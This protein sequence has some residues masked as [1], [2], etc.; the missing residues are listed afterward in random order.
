MASAL[1]TPPSAGPLHERITTPSLSPPPEKACGRSGRVWKEGFSFFSIRFLHGYITLFS[2]FPNFNR[3]IEE[4]GGW[5]FFFPR[6]LLFV[7]TDDFQIAARLGT[8]LFPFSCPGGLEIGITSF[9]PFPSLSEVIA[10]SS[11]PSHR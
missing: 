4:R 8:N 7:K 11:F 1:P 9:L 5:I 2:P 6:P 3:G 10:S